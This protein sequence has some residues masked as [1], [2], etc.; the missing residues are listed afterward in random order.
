MTQTCLCGSTPF[1]RSGQI[2]DPKGK[3]LHVFHMDCPEHGIVD[4]GFRDM[5]P[6]LK[7]GWLTPQACDGLLNLQP[8][9]TLI[10]KAPD[11]RTALVEWVEYELAPEGEKVA[12]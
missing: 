4:N 2:Q 5:R 8:F 6:V 12:A 10:E 11:K 9:A 7:R 1:A 3:V